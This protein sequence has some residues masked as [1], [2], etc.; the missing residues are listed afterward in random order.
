MFCLGSQK[1]G[2]PNCTVDIAGY[3]STLGVLYHWPLTVGPLSQNHYIQPGKQCWPSW[4]RQ[5]VILPGEHGISGKRS[6]L[7]LLELVPWQI[8]LTQGVSVEPWSS[9]LDYLLILM[10]CTNK[11]FFWHRQSEA[12]SN[13][14]SS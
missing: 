7:W 11:L 4:V 3:W 9:W 6:L 5:R 8:F 2:A 13:F 14:P 1:M 12:G 10:I